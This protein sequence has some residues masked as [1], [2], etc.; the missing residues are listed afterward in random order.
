MP[1]KRS[2]FNSGEGMNM[3]ENEE[4]RDGLMGGED[5]IDGD[6]IGGRSAADEDDMGGEDEADED[7]M[8][9]EDKTDPKA[10]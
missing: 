7:D 9:G 10:M 8:G 4:E 5:A 3:E 2:A 6:D 1:A